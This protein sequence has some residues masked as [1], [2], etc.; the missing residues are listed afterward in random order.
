MKKIICMCLGGLGNRIRPLAS[1]YKAADTIE[2]DVFLWWVKNYRCDCD[3]QD[4]FENKLNQISVFDI[5]SLKS[6]KIYAH[7]YSAVQKYVRVTGDTSLSAV[8]EKFPRVNIGRF[9]NEIKTSNEENVMVL[10]DRF[11][12]FGEKEKKFL[13]SLRPVKSI[14]QKIK[15]YIE[16][17]NI[18]ENVIGVHARGS[19]FA[20]GFSLTID[21]YIQK[22]QVYLNQNP[23][24]KFLV[25]SD[26]FEYESKIADKFPLNVIKLSSKKEYVCKY[27][28]EKKGYTNNAYMSKDAMQ[29]SVLDLFLLA[30]TK[31]LIGHEASSFF[32]ICQILSKMPEEKYFANIN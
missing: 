26:D 32:Q 16:Q 4:L 3:F 29:D 24:I 18:G 11:V 8:F 27:K 2:R 15:R 6:M 14:R 22:M 25:C 21:Y 28:K 9:L 5:L 13:W 12:D 1:C 31:F 23:N 7:S 10:N 30:K 20:T 19:D 17:F